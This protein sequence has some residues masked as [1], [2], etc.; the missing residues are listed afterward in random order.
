MSSNDSSEHSDSS[1]RKRVRI[2][3]AQVVGHVDSLS[4]QERSDSF[5]S[6]EQFLDTKNELKREC[7]NHR[8]ER[9]YSDCLTHAYNTA[10]R[11]AANTNT[12]E[13]P[14]NAKSEQATASL[15][16]PTLDDVSDLL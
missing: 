13:V 6:A 3:E 9:R 2:A 5:W 16:S 10:A 11:L 1:S 14:N 12:I 8:Q 4:E 7:R 15:S